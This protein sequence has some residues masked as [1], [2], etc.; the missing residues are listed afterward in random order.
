[1]VESPSLGQIRADAHEE[2]TRSG[3]VVD[4]VNLRAGTGIGQRATEAGFAFCSAIAT[5]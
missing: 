2:T 3:H 5:T 4:S 1:M